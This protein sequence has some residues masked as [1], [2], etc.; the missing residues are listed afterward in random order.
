MGVAFVTGMQGDT[1]I[2]KKRIPDNHLMCTAKHFVAYSIPQSGINIAPAVIGERDLRSLHLVPFEAAVKKANIY[3]LMPGYHEVDGI[4][5]HCN[6]W[7]LTDILRNEWGFKGYVFSDYGAIGMLNNFHKVSGSKKETALKAITAGVDLE[8]PNRYAY[9]ELIN[10]VQNKELEV[11]VVD[12][13]VRH[14]L[15]AKFKAGLFEKAFAVTSN[16]A[17]L[18]HTRSIFS[19]HVTWLK[20]RLFC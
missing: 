5:V 17:S 2:T 11:K 13:A 15:T 1:A 4:P 8:A 19:F 10:L 3:S 12:N 18:I 9:G 6:K 16:I 7:L 14:I 20:N